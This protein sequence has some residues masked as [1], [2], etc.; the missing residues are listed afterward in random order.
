MDQHEKMVPV[1]SRGVGCLGTTSAP[2]KMP[3]SLQQD[4]ALTQAFV[5]LK[6][7]ASVG[8]NFIKH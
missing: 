5:L 7:L 4:F 3:F 1:T 8:C 2:L 6:F